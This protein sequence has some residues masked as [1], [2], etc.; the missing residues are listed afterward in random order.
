M[1]FDPI[2]LVYAAPLVALWAVWIIATKRRSHQALAVLKDNLAAGLNEPSTL[3]P[4]I[5]PALCLGCAACARACPEKTVLGIIDGKAMLIEPTMCVGHGACQ[6]ACPTKA[7]SLVFGT[8]TR[9]VDLP[10]LSP[11]FETTVPGIFV[12][13]ELGGMGLIKNA[14]EQGRQAV[15]S[16]AARAK[17]V[18]GGVDVLD[19]VIVG[20]GPAGISASLGALERGLSFETIDQASLGGSIAH[21][22][23]GKVVMTAPAQLPIVGEVKFGEISKERLLTFWTDVI[24]RTKL[25]PRFEEQ[26]TAINRIGD[27]FEIRSSKGRYLAKSVLLA[28]GRRGTPRPLGVPGEELD[29]VYYRLIDPE[30]FAGRRVLVVGGGDSALEA[31]AMLAMEPGTQVT[32]SYRGAAYTRARQKN[33]DRVDE[34]TGTRRM[35]EMLGSE[36][37]QIEAGSVTL[38]WHGERRDLPNDAVIICAGGLLPTQFLHDM[39]VSV[40]TKFGTV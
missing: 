30:Q 3:H 9:G 37:V 18:N 14:I 20:C 38:D 15:E 40:E 24:A 2:L 27:H 13:G 26:V 19:L 23:R 34:L 32:L 6:A 21:F 35:T 31:A 16:A 36:V 11:D 7:I 12:A 25:K 33:R 28:I 8:A 4:V 29:K 10:V 5:D 22:P 1:N 39:G 17:H